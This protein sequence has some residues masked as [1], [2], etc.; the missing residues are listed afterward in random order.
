MNA[1]QAWMGTQGYGDRSILDVRDLVSEHFVIEGRK[2][3]ENGVPRTRPYL[4]KLQ[5]PTERAFELLEDNDTEV[6]EGE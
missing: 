5:G 2:A 6:L 3:R 1:M 4:A